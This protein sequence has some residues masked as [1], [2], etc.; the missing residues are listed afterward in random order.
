VD[1]LDRVKGWRG[2]NRATPV[3]ITGSRTAN[4]AAMEAGEVDATINGVVEG[5][6]LEEQ[7]KGRL[8]L[9][10]ADYLGP[11]QLYVIFAGT[12]LV[13]RNPGAI[14]RFLAGWFES[15]AYMRSHQA[16]TIQAMRHVLGYSPAIAE[17]CYDELV[18]KLSP[19]GRFDSKALAAL[20]ASFAD[21]KI[22]PASANLSKLYTE[23]F[24]PPAS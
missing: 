11:F 23:R 2:S 24:L 10:V 14:R 9:T 13:Q 20:F 5:W 12:A 16:E 1:E 7:H 17:R 4:L 15:V 3:V 18:P 22:V 6:R 19:D 21:L 8:L